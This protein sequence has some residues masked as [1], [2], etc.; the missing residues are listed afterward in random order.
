MTSRGPAGAF[1]FVQRVGR[2]VARTPGLGVL[3]AP[4]RA[5]GFALGALVKERLGLADPDLPKT[6][7]SLALTAQVALDE[8]LLG[9]MRNPRR[10]PTD[11]ELRAV[12]DDLESATDIYRR[13]GWLHDP[14]TF[15]VDPP[16][17]VDITSSQGWALGTFFERISW[18]SGFEATE[19]LPGHDRWM[20]YEK[21]KTANAYLIRTERARPWLVC[22]HGFGTGVPMSDFFAFR[23][24]RLAEELRLNLAFPVLPL[25][26]PRRASRLSGAELLSY[27]LLDFV[28]GMG[29]AAYDMRQLVRWLRLEGATS[30]GLYGMSLGS[31]AGA[32]L[33]ALE[34]G[35]DLMIAGVPLCDM[36]QMI[37]HH[38]TA[39][40]RSRARQNGLGMEKLHDLYR[41]VSP[42]SWPSKVPTD[43]I[44]MYAGV[45]D[46]MSTPGQAHRLWRHWGEPKVLWYDGGHLAFLWSGRVVKF[47]DEA[48]T[49]SGF[50]VEAKR[51]S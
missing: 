10:Y 37:D 16:P 31:Y 20:T 39:K 27:N 48:L 8:A 2:T 22:I 23:A 36:A 51:A 40:M 46:R 34:P 32:L 25:H 44:F 45:G 17:L 50:V 41:V 30:I 7:P 14:T 3:W 35:I 26:G 18:P 13:N 9:V 24:R 15:H 42:L 38:A 21:N 49:E 28:Y 19:G 11:S 43:K 47:L 12:G 33:S 6:R 29:Q 4:P 1:E 5:A